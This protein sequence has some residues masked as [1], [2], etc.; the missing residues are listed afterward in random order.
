MMVWGGLSRAEVFGDDED[1]AMSANDGTA[2]GFRG[3]ETTSRSQSLDTTIHARGIRNM[4]I[5][6]L[7]GYDLDWFLSTFRKTAWGALMTATR[8]KGSKHAP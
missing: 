1:T 6:W 4:V 8:R 2:L 7:N 3:A 5:W